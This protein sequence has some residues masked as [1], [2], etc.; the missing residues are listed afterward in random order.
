MENFTRMSLIL[1]VLGFTNTSCIVQFS[2]ID[3]I[4]Q[5]Y[6]V[7]YTIHIIKAFHDFNHKVKNKEVTKIQ[8][9]YVHS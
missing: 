1:G 6:K 5:E 4:V 9:L 8:E 7:A 3:L 2:M